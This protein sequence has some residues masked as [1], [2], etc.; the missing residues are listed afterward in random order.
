MP[1]LA[2]DCPCDTGP[3]VCCDSIF[4]KGDRIRTVAWNAVLSCSEEGC[5]SGREAR[6]YM[7]LDADTPDPFGDSVIV[8]WLNTTPVTQTRGG[9]TPQIVAHRC[10]FRVQVAVAGWPILG[11]QDGRAV[12]PTPSAMNS[13]SKLALSHSELA[14]RAVVA[15]VQANTLW[16][17]TPGVIFKGTSV[18]QMRPRPPSSLIQRI[19]FNVNVD[20]AL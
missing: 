1:I 13:A 12:M 2:A 15:A 8:A 3:E 11:T 14:Y 20:I 10:E 18:S 6:T 4:L 9:H 16:T 7:T 5:C 17:S 19:I